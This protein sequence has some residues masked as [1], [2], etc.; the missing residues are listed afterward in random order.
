MDSTDSTKKRYA[1][2]FIPLESNPSVLNDLMHSLGASD[3]LALSDV[4]SVDDPTLLGLMSRPVFAFILVLPTSEEYERHR[5]STKVHSD[6][7]EDS[8]G[9]EIVWLRQTINNACG[10]YAILH[11]V[12]NLEAREF[13]SM[14]I[15][16]MLSPLY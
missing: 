16:L 2:A 3:S 4:W 11:A 1:K 15:M 6:S 9:E 12:C 8:K 5:Q 7:A 10:L 13:I 14:L